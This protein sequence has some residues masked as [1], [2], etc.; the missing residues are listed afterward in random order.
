MI[1]KLDLI[2]EQ[3][4]Q[5]GSIIR[6][7]IVERDIDILR[8][9]G[10]AD[11]IT[12]NRDYGFNIKYQGS[13][14]GNNKSL[15][16][17]SDNQ[18]G[19][20]VEALSILQ[21]GKVGIGTSLARAELDVYG[22]CRVTD[23]TVLEGAT[24]AGVNISDALGG[25]LWGGITTLGDHVSV[26]Q[27]IYHTGDLD[28]YIH[29]TED[30]IRLFAG[31][32]QL[33]DAFEG[34]QDYVKL[35]DGGDVDINLNDVLHVNGNTGRVGINSTIPSRDLDIDGGVRLQGF[36]YDKDN[37]AGTNGQILISTGTGVDW[38]TG[39][40][41]NAITGVTI[42]DEGTQKGTLGSIT[43][44]DFVGSGVT[45]SASGNIST[46]TVEA[47]TAA[48]SNKQVQF[49][50]NGLFEGAEGLNYDLHTQKVA[51]GTDVFGSRTLTVN[52]EVGVS[53]NVYGYRF[54]ATEYIPSALNELVTKN[55]LDNFQSAITI[56]KSVGAATTVDL[57]GN[58]DNGSSGVGAILWGKTNANLTV[59]G[60]A[61]TFD[62]RILVK[63]QTTLYE[64]GIYT[65]SRVGSGS[66]SWQLTRDAGYDSDAEI[67][68]GDFKLYR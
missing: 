37:Q 60:V 4:A 41:T 3:Q 7:N 53:S 16:V 67:A 32:E 63:N 57:D 40:P 58:Y 30:R 12:A 2:L 68:P 51:I 48:G 43:I 21:D 11:D 47:V 61:A 64:N 31:G 62:E 1:M 35:G 26:G 49:N 25:S 50:D 55:Y 65:V 20:Q 22:E 45:A 18:T 44:L 6:T 27:T 8:I 23:L 34:A 46:I 13:H 33:I 38:Q 17:F 52:G 39:A 42:K 66:T 9:N 10:F 36:S 29:F 19:T 59:D 54:F 56:Q 14:G 24:F 28:T 15:S 5:T